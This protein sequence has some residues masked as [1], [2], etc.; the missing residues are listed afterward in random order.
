MTLGQ[1]LVIPLS[2]TQTPPLSSQRKD[3]QSRQPRNLQQLLYSWGNQVLQERNLGSPDRLRRRGSW[4][5]GG[6]RSLTSPQSQGGHGTG[7]RTKLCSQ[8]DR[9]LGAVWREVQQR[10][11][12]GEQ[13]LQH[14][15]VGHAEGLGHILNVAISLHK[16][17]LDLLCQ[18]KTLACKCKLSASPCSPCVAVT[19]SQ[20]LNL[21][22]RCT[23]SLE[24]L[25]P[26]SICL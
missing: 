16:N 18:G 14:T 3:H 8:E 11:T 17:L 26:N 2:R 6:Q 23:I 19:R 5:G 22:C 12:G 25:A 13:R 4:P 10:Q 20:F 7:S 24:L 21:L 1:V 9:G 15:P